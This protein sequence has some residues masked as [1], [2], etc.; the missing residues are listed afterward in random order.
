MSQPKAIGK[1]A[2]AGQEILNRRYRIANID[3]HR[4]RILDFGCGNGAQTAYFLTDDNRVVGLDV[5]HERLTQASPKIEKVLYD[6]RLIPF[7]SET[8]DIVISFEVLEHTED[9]RKSVEEVY[10]VL[11]RGGRFILSVP[12]K[13]WIFETHGTYLPLNLRRL[14]FVSWLPD[15][16]H[17]RIARARIYTRKRICSLL[18]GFEI[19]RVEYITAPMD[20][21]KHQGLKKFLRSAIFRGDTTSIPFLSTSVFVEARKP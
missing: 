1:P 12:N 16:I 19:V 13:W 21:V 2:E 15:V 7:P 17:S 9:D 11:K 18:K 3:A 5:E 4:K 6:G 14:P 20:V 8:F 10:R